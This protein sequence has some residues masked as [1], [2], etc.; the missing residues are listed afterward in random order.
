V[1]II[2]R[3]VLVDPRSMVFLRWGVSETFIAS[4]E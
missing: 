1:A 2:E 3:V 4:P